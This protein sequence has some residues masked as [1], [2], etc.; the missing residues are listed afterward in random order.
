MEP[1]LIKIND[2]IRITSLSRS[3][4]YRMIGNSDF[5]KQVVIGNR[6]ARWSLA[7]VKEWCHEQIH[8]SQAA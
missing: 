5:P 4:V 1:I 3:T 7:E 8:A 6:Q 2:V